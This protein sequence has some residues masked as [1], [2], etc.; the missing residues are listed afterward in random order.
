MMAKSWIRYFLIGATVYCSS[1][2]SRGPGDGSGGGSII[3]FATQ[4]CPILLDLVTL[5][6]AYANL[7]LR[8]GVHCFAPPVA[9]DAQPAIERAR[10]TDLQ[11]L[12]AAR[13]RVANWAAA[14][15]SKGFPIAHGYLVYLD[16]NLETMNFTRTRYAIPNLAR[17]SDSRVHTV[18]LFHRLY[19]A[20]LSSPLWDTL[21][22][23]TKTGLII[24][25]GGREIQ[26]GKSHG[27]F[28]DTSLEIITATIVNDFSSEGAQRIESELKKSPRLYRLL[29]GISRSPTDPGA[30]MAIDFNLSIDSL[31]QQR[32]KQ[33]ADALATNPLPTLGELY[34]AKL[35]ELPRALASRFVCQGF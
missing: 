17:P 22:E 16:R 29:E 2:L 33:R 27:E 34:C 11:V 19:G 31:I 28:K 18:I 10:G 32:Q 6:P 1:A 7:A 21:G 15:K 24:H 9:P 26:L 3:Q 30:K 4:E 35:I 13:T 20:I 25:E 14:A 12:G 23:W 8:K 5:N